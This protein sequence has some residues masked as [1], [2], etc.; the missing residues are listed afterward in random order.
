MAST[1][2][3]DPSKSA[4]QILTDLIN[5]SNSHR[6][7]FSPYAYGALKFRNAKAS[8]MDENFDSTVQISDMSAPSESDW[9]DLWYNRVPI[10]NRLNRPGVRP[11]AFDVAY[12]S[13]YDMLPVIN[14]HFNVNLTESDIEDAVI[15][16]P[17][18]ADEYPVIVPIIVKAGALIYRGATGLY[19][20]NPD[21]TQF[22][23][24][25]V[26][27]AD[28]SSLN[29]AV[30]SA[31]IL[32]TDG[33]VVSSN[34]EAE[35]AMSIRPTNDEVL[36]TGTLGVYQLD[37]D[38]TTGWSM[39][40]SLAL[41]DTTLGNDVT[42]LYRTK[43]SVEQPGSSS[44]KMEMYLQRTGTDL[45]FRSQDGN[46]VVPVTEVLTGT[47]VQLQLNP[48]NYPELFEGANVGIEGALLGNYRFTAESE[49]IGEQASKLISTVETQFIHHAKCSVTLISAVQEHR[50]VAGETNYV[51]FTLQVRISGQ[52]GVP[53]TLEE[54][55]AYSVSLPLGATLD[56]ATV[57]KDGISLSGTA[58]SV[59]QG[60]GK[61]V[62]ELTGS[63][64]IEDSWDDIE[65]LTL[66]IFD[67][68]K[69]TSLTWD[70][71]PAIVEGGGKGDPIEP[72]PGYTFVKL[73]PASLT[74]DFIVGSTITYTAAVWQDQ[75]LLTINAR[76]VD[77][78]SLELLLNNLES[79]QEIILDQSFEGLSI[80][81]RE[82][83]THID[84]D[85][86][87]SISDPFGPVTPAV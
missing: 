40:L 80:V 22:L 82:T 57:L 29:E 30:T 23:V 25:T 64:A 1:I 11:L 8:I 7:Q 13:L 17:A 52:A 78:E 41:L 50:L 18:T 51:P 5:Q 76:L 56:P 44:P 20:E 60:L 36:P 10:S 63:V 35:L 32:P 83:A 9:L 67:E 2:T 55:A 14:A 65:D 87:V 15:E 34:N 28:S 68:V 72:P 74:G 84:G 3:Q 85:T 26:S 21:S 38:T 31:S 43:L 42:K 70:I 48:F 58:L 45:A 69:S 49:R 66:E 81:I 54:A 79:G 39:N 53:L 62:Y 16:A 33:F 77:S 46:H 71:L 19:L 75:E 37:A 6:P 73:E 12:T 47:L 4:E 27:T 24:K 86:Y 61:G 59:P